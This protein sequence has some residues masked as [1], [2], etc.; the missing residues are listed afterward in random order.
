M[1]SS[2][3]LH[4]IASQELKSKRIYKDSDSDDY[5]IEKS[6]RCFQCRRVDHDMFSLCHTSPFFVYKHEKS[7][8]KTE[9][10][11][12]ELYPE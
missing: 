8:K 9:F 2:V 4:L 11:V 1:V 5:D 10:I 6:M 12:R 7:N 3:T